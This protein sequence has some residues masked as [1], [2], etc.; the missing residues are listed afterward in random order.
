M[1]FFINIDS[2]PVISCVSVDDITKMRLLSFA[3]L[4]FFLAMIM[5]LYAKPHKQDGTGEASNVS[6]DNHGNNLQEVSPNNNT[7][8]STRTGRRKRDFYRKFN[9]K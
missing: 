4:F 7:S 6:T 5:N 3:N 1:Y 8:G 2:F 9:K